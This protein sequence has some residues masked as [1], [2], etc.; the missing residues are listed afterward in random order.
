[1]GACTTKGRTNRDKK[2]PSKNIFERYI[3]FYEFFYIQK[4]E[5][6]F[7]S[8]KVGCKKIAEILFYI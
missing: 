6:I 1:M 3:N 7:L 2:M 4:S 8:W 5:F